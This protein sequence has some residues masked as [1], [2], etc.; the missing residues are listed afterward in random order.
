MPNKTITQVPVVAKNIKRITIEPLT[1]IGEVVTWKLTYDYDPVD[2]LGVSIRKI[3]KT[4]ASMPLSAV[5]QTV[6]QNFVTNQIVLDANLA[7]GT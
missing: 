3:L 6:L 7:E 2:D 5:Q 1:I 4:K